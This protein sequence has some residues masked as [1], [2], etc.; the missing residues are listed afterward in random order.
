MLVCAQ[1]SVCLCVRVCV[2]AVLVHAAMPQQQV[3]A[4]DEVHLNSTHT[5]RAKR[6]SACSFSGV[7]LADGLRVCDLYA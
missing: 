3:K 5:S 2:C 4:E 1:N 7:G 6:A